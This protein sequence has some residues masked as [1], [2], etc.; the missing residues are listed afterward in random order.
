MSCDLDRL[1]GD[2]VR[3]VLTTATESEPYVLKAQNLPQPPAWMETDHLYIA[4]GIHEYEDYFRADMLWW[5]AS[6][7]TYGQLAL[8]ILAVLFHPDPP[9]VNLQLTHPASEIKRLV[10]RYEYPP[11]DE[12]LD[13]GYNTRPY[14]FAYYPG[15]TAWYDHGRYR[16]VSD[17]PCFWLSGAEPGGDYEAAWKDRDTVIG[18]GTDVGA[19]RFAEL[20][21]SAGRP[22]NACVEYA[23]EGDGSGLARS[24]GRW[25]AE[26]RL[27]LPGSDAWDPAQWSS[28]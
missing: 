9:E 28:E 7:E 3:I 10:V 4:K 16:E 5:F 24:V 19:T 14:A 1:Y 20:L 23:L 12:Y 15:E 25:S 26:V 8:L 17:L 6:K 13:A 11:S 18:F 2:L 22:D 27:W 21:L